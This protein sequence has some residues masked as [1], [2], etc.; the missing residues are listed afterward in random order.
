MS[1][2][3]KRLTL[4]THFRSRNLN[5]LDV[6]SFLRDLLKHLRGPLF[7]FWDRGTIHRRKEISDLPVEVEVGPAEL[8]G[9]TSGVLLEPFG[10]CAHEGFKILE[11]QTLLRHKTVHS[12]RPTD[13]QIA[14]E[15]NSIKTGYRPGDFSCIV[16]NEVLRSVPP[17]VAVW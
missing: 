4:Y 10:M 5:G 17:F 16:V 3:G 7:L 2:K 1:P 11:E 12:L 6:R 14:L 13:R 9:H 8:F 15:K